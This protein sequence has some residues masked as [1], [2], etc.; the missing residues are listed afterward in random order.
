VSRMDRP[1]VTGTELACDDSGWGSNGREIGVVRTAGGS[2]EGVEDRR[3][4]ARS[5]SCI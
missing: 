1:G 2:K 5:V 4:F 3:D